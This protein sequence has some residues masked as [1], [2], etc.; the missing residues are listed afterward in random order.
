MTAAN[1]G[2]RFVK[3]GLA[4][5]RPAQRI[6]LQDQGMPVFG[7]GIRELLIRVEATGSLRHAASDMGLAYSKAWCIVRRAEQHLGVPLLERRAGGAGGGGSTLSG[8]GRWLVRTFGGLLD[9]ANALL[10]ALY[11]KHFGNWYDGRG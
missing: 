5:I 6:W 3:A 1:S 10:D 2:G 7:K 8:E 9:E 4:D 11:A